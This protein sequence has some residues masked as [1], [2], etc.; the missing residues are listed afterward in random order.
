MSL[1]LNKIQL[2]SIKQLTRFL[3]YHNYSLCVAESCT[4]GM[5]SSVLTSQ[6]GSS[7]YFKGGLIVYSNNMKNKLLDIK[8]DHIEKYGVVSEKI[9]EL[10]ANRA[11]IKCGSD[12]SIATTGWI[13]LSNISSGKPRAWIAISSSDF[14]ISECVYLNGNRIDKISNV[15]FQSIQLFI[16]S[17]F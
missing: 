3:L 12:F 8:Q 6:S 7:K 15:V 10:M 17:T 5:L 4:G 9:V 2:I 14:T 13:E 1:L 11:R 16:K